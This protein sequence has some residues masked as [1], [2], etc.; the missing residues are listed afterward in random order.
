MVNQEPGQGRR[1]ADAIKRLPTSVAEVIG[2][3]LKR[4]TEQFWW[5][6]HISA[7][8]ATLVGRFRHH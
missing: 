1:S 4:M 3:F 2:Q 6:E 8:I 5:E 7:T